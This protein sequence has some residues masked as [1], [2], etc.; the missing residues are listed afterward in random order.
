MIQD[1]MDIQKNKVN[2]DKQINCCHQVFDALIKDAA[3]ISELYNTGAYLE[4]NIDLPDL[5]TKICD[6][7]KLLTDHQ[8]KLFTGLMSSICEC[9]NKRD[10][11][12]LAD[13]LRF[14]LPYILTHSM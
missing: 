3:R 11:L 8:Q 6:Q 2:Q 4:G 13:F 7:F 14:E 5:L 9:Q 12:S 1:R 10:Y